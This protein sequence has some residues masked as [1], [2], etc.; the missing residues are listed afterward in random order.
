[1]RSDFSTASAS[2]WCRCGYRDDPLVQCTCRPGEAERYLRRVSG[3]L[4][5]RIDCF[6]AMPR[7]PP[8]E[9]LRAAE[10]EASAPVARRIADAWDLALA[11]NGG[12]PNAALAGRR[13][14]GAAP[15]DAA[16]TRLLERMAE[17]GAYSARSIHRA[18]RVA[19]TVADLRGLERLEAEDIAAAI[20]LRQPDRGASRRAA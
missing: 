3:P 13:L 7:V 1:M 6:V 10:P 20:A 15:L 14:R 9:L 12:R 17:G 18:V 19:R 16:A 11:R 5:D 4:L 8:Q 2:Q